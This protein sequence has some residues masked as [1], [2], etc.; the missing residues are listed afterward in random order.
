MIIFDIDHFK[1][2][3]D[4]YGHNVGDI[5]LRQLADHIK[6][7]LRSTDIF[8]RWGGEEFIILVPNDEG[9]G[10]YNLIESLRK[11]TETFVFPTAGKVTFSAGIGVYKDGD[12]DIDLIKKADDALYKAKK[13]GR[14]QTQIY[15]E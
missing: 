10:A 12:S 1:S 5:V 9:D 3:N 15:C 13:S 14:N 11:H 7:R 4:N 8:G 6:S 2:V